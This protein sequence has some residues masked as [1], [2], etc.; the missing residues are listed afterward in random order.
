[1]GRF[2]SAPQQ[3]MKVKNAAKPRRMKHAD[4]Q[5]A[6]KA[7]A[8]RR[9]ASMERALKAAERGSPGRPAR[10]APKIRKSNK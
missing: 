4:V 7:A 2:T 3:S 8:D 6:S 5:D 10:P 9:N 1:M